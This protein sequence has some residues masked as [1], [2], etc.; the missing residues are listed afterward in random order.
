LTLS[1]P[2]E[3]TLSATYEG[4]INFA[5]SSDTEQH[6]VV[7]AATITT[8]TSDVPD[9]SQAGEAFTVTVEV[10]SSLTIPTGKVMITVSENPASCIATLIDGKGN[11]E[12]TLDTVGDYILIATYEGTI[13]FAS[14][15][16]TEAHTV[17]PVPQWLFLPLVV[18]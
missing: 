3:Y 4:T 8:I 9:A 11:C 17:I 6:T 10:T 12:L 1:N 13:N 5:S 15:S 18:K 16:D 2:G 14:S 7:K